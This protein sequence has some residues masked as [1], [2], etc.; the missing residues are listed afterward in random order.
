MINKVVLFLLF[1][2]M[3][4]I[5][6]YSVK[7]VEKS[8]SSPSERILLQPHLV[9]YFVLSVLFFLFLDLKGYRHSVSLAILLAFSYGF[10]ME[11]IQ[12]FLPYREF[13]LIDSSMNFLGSSAIII[14]KALPRNF[15]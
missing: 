7:P 10:F 2:W 13:S 9:A 12:Y 14:F 5:L 3:L 6:Y 1:V 15:L 11:T 8:F 4:L